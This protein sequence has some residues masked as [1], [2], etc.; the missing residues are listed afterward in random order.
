VWSGVKE[1][2]TS[3]PKWIPRVLWSEKGVTNVSIFATSAGE[4]SDTGTDNNGSTES[5]W[6]GERERKADRRNGSFL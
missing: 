4:R 2:V 1:D 6:G 3:L 5:E